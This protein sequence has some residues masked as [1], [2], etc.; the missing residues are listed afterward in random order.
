MT[1][2]N[3]PVYAQDLVM[4]DVMYLIGALYINVRVYTH[5]IKR[6]QKNSQ[7]QSCKIVLLFEPG[8]FI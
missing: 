1:I 6:Y 2:V 8:I 5:N 3:Y 4:S 7:S